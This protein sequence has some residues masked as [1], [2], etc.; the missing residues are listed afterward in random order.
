MNRVEST[1]LS[2]YPTRYMGDDEISLTDL[3]LTLVEHRRWLLGSWLLL[4]LPGLIYGLMKAPEYEYSTIVQIGTALEGSA[5]DA[6]IVPIQTPETTVSQLNALYIPRGI[7][8]FK[9]DHGVKS[10]AWEV[11][12]TAIGGA[13]LVSL[14]TT[15]PETD[16]S[17]VTLLHEA[18]TA[19]LIT[20]LEARRDVRLNSYRA[21]LKALDENTSAPAPMFDTHEAL[22]QS[23]GTASGHG[24]AKSPPV[25]TSESP[26]MNPALLLERLQSLEEIRRDK[27]TADFLTT[28]LAQIR[29]TRPLE[30]GLRSESP[31]GIGKA[32]LILLFGLVAFFLALFTAFTA[33]FLKNARQEAQARHRA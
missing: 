4:F 30:T 11:K 3:W 12:A 2:D 5:D 33:A 13:D 32:A 29:I 8:A 10:L 23:S 20:D 25:P 9:A 17:G 26:D 14:T 22:S 15:A 31:A 24:D 27:A 7:Q 18:V 16:Q 6:Q 21:H 19:A 28:Q 1:Q